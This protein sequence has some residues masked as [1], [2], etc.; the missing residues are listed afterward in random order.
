MPLGGA[1]VGGV[2][3]LGSGVI[4]SVEAGQDRDAANAARQAAVQQW[5]SVNVP[6]PKQQEIELQNYQVTG[7]LSPQMEQAF[8]QSQTALNNVSL[9]PASRAAEVA[10][11]TKMQGLASNGGLDAQAEQQ[12]QQAINQT[13]ANEKGQRGAIIQ[14]AMARGMGQGGGA[15]LEA[16]LEASQG[17]ANQA[18]ASGQSAAAA[19]QMRALQALAES[20]QMGATLNSQDYAQAAAKAQAADAINRFNTQNSQNVQN[21]NVTNANA[22]Q[23]A[24]LANAQS[25]ANANTGVAN[26]QE[27]YNKGLVQQQFNNEATKAAGASGQYAGVAAQDN[28]NA[29]NTANMWSGIGQSLAKGAGAIAQYSNNKSTSST[30]TPGTPVQV[31]D[32]PAGTYPATEPVEAYGGEIPKPP[33]NVGYAKGG[34]V[35]MSPSHFD[36]ILEMIRQSKGHTNAA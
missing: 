10:A 14:N 5:L 32:V 16:Q 13:N 7:Q 23:A 1:I 33:R 4:G 8:Q 24:N 11:L 22:A 25:V 15:M 31:Q 35:K 21:A 36:Q 28:A 27:A 20:S 29:T 3:A 34:E 30:S 17:D 2:A 26:Q 6:D 19:A 18:A 12:T 9:D